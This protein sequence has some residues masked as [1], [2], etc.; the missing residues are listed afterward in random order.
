[1]TLGMTHLARIHNATP[2]YVLPTKKL[3]SMRARLVQLERRLRLGMT[4]LETTRNAMRPFA[5]LTNAW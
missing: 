3:S 1:M 2:P 5:M 4:H